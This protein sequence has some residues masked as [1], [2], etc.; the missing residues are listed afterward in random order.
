LL[1]FLE[2]FEGMTKNE[3][4]EC[5]FNSLSQ[6]LCNCMIM[7]VEKPSSRD[8]EFITTE[9]G[10]TE[11]VMTEPLRPVRTNFLHERCFGSFS[12]VTCTL[13]KLPK[14]CSYEKC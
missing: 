14:R 9:I 7:M 2:S 1:T 6:L 8:S 3:D 4:C 10:T 13:K 11:L 5:P 12:L